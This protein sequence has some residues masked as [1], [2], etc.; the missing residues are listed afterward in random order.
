MHVSLLVEI[1]VKLIEEKKDAE[2]AEKYFADH[3]Q[4]FGEKFER[5][6][7][8]T[9]YLV[10]TLDRWNDGKKAEEKAR[11][12]H[13]VNSCVDDLVRAAKLQDQALA[14]NAAYAGKTSE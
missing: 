5:L 14:R 11:V 7:R 10:G 9:G 13:S 3:S 8:I 2:T 6:R 4:Y 12:K 1:G